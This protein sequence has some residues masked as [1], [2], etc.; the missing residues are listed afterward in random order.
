M[1]VLFIIATFGEST[2]LECE[3]LAASFICLYLFP[4]CDESGRLYLPSQELCLEVSMDV[5][6]Q[7]WATAELFDQNNQLPD[8]AA[9][10]SSVSSR[11]MS[12]VFLDG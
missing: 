10:P 3:A 7:E 9:L 8:C 1:H 12:M 11:F 5:C 6:Q 4:F 2:S